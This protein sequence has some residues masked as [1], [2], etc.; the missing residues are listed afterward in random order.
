M[1]AQISARSARASTMA[2]STSSGQAVAGG[3]SNSPS[4]V[5]APEGGA[6]SGGVAAPGAAEIDS[7]LCPLFGPAPPG[8]SGA[9]PAA[10]GPPK[11]SAR[12]GPPPRPG[13]TA[14]PPG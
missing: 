14:A 9:R 13:Q 2:H 11:G 1:P 4:I 6:A 5:S 8:M 7:L 10:P 12:P 3:N